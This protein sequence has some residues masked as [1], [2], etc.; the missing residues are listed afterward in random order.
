MYLLALEALVP[1]SFCLNMDKMSNSS[2]A[3][4]EGRGSIG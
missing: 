1:C 4:A 2:D 3:N